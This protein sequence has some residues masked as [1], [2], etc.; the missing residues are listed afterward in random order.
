VKENSQNLGVVFSVIIACTANLVKSLFLNNYLIYSPSL[1]I[2][3]VG[4]WEDNNFAE[5][6]PFSM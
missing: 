2:C 4:I 1:G 6:L 3:V 5:T